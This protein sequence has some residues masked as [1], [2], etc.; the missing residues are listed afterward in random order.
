MPKLCRVA[1]SLMCAGL[2][3]GV[4]ASLSTPAAG[5]A[6]AG[7]ATKSVREGVYTREQA[8]RGQKIFAARCVGCHPS[9]K[10]REP[11]FLATW[12]GQTAHALF[13]SIRT[14]MPQE[15]PGG[16]RRQEYADLLAYLLHVNKLPAGSAELGLSD[17]ALKKIVIEPPA[18]KE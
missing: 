9:E 13:V 1:A 8:L 17:D 6:Q 18:R 2:L 7:A 16:L 4:G 5:A 12:S 3:A 15:N 10:F 14:T 11:I